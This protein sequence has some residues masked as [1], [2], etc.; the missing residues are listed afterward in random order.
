[1]SIS[2]RQ[3]DPINLQADESEMHLRNNIKIQGNLPAINLFQNN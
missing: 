3:I 2:A 1:M